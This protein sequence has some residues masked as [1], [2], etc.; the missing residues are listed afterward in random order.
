MGLWS[1]RA[2]VEF[3]SRIAQSRSALCS[4]MKRCGDIIN[5]RVSMPLLLP[6]PVI[7]LGGFY[8]T[9]VRKG[10]SPRRMS[11]APWLCPPMMNPAMSV[12]VWIKSYGTIGQNRVSSS[13]ESLT[14]TLR[15]G[16]LL[17]KKRRTC[18]RQSSKSRNDVSIRTAVPVVILLTPIGS[19]PTRRDTLAELCQMGGHGPTARAR[20]VGIIPGERMGMAAPSPFKSFGR[21]RGC[22]KP[23]ASGRNFAALACPIFP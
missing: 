1:W 7:R 2:L 22:V 10:L 17:R 21:Q 6:C 20:R 3:A 16:P 13:A 5:S 23:T 15:A 8:P 14:S 19:A 11:V 12:A 18:T 9:N 4:E